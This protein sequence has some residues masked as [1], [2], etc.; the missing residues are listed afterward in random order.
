[1]DEVTLERVPQVVVALKGVSQ[2]P[3]WGYLVSIVGP[4]GRTREHGP[5]LVL[6][7]AEPGVA[8]GECS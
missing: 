5:G 6:R 1:M 7:T 8:E 3:V 4:L 2:Q